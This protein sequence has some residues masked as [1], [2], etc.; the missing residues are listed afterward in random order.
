MQ[1]NRNCIKVS[2]VARR[3][4]D[5]PGDIIQGVTPQCKPKYFRR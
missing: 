2:G 4:G 5:A 3:K 1:K